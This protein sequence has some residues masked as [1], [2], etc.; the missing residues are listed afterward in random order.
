MNATCP[1]RAAHTSARVVD[2]PGTF[3]PIPW[4]YTVQYAVQMR[5]SADPPQLSRDRILEVALE[6][7]EREGL[8]ALS[9]RRLAQELDVWPMAVY[10]WFRDKDEL[11][12]AIAASTAAAVPVPGA[13]ESWRDRLRELLRGA[14]RAMAHDPAGMGGSLARAF[15]TPEALRLSESALAILLRAGLPRREAASAWRMLWSYTYGFAMFEIAATPEE[16]RRRT[17]AAIAGLADNEFPTLLD[18]A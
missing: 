9:M 8:R 6:L 10:H 1:A 14:H 2:R 17:R 5:K 4:L 13:G 18:M 15:L 3:S 11:L 7:I 16:T 12:D